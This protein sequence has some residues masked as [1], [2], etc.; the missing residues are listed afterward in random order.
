MWFWVVFY[1]MYGCVVFVFVVVVNRDK[2]L[3]YV[4]IDGVFLGLVSYG[5]YNLMVY[6][7]IEGFILFIMLIDW[8]W[9]MCL[10]SVSVMVGWLGF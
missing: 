8:V 3:F 5:V 4:G 6:S 2:L 1:F 10:I 9:G 7:I